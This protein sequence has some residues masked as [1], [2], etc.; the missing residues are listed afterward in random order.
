MNMRAAAYNIQRTGMTAFLKLLTKHIHILTR[1]K[2][3]VRADLSVNLMLHKNIQNL[4]A[5]VN[6]RIK[7]ILYGII[8]MANIKAPVKLLL[9]LMV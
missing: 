1:L 4:S 2:D 8:V 3:K 7:L 6:D 5:I 9:F